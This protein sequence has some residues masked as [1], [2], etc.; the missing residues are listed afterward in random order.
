MSVLFLQKKPPFDTES[1]GGPVF[2]GATI[3]YTAPL[4]GATTNAVGV[5]PLLYYIHLLGGPHQSVRSR[6]RRLVLTGLGPPLDQDSDFAEP[7]V[8]C[9][10][11]MRVLPVLQ[12]EPHPCGG[13]RFVESGLLTPSVVVREARFLLVF[14]LRPRIRF[15]G[16]VESV[17]LLLNYWS[18]QRAGWRSAK[19][20]R[21]GEDRR[22]DHAPRRAG[23]TVIDDI[24]DGGAGTN[25]WNLRATKMNE[26]RGRSPPNV[27][28]PA[29]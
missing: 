22:D 15:V 20:D 29:L 1:D 24:R 7:L 9:C 13:R 6:F 14:S 25:H 16:L 28:R 23:R 11:N 18:D 26:E 21:A 4:G 5:A 8:L 17:A 19:G 10:P 27:G 3:Y 12:G 2:L